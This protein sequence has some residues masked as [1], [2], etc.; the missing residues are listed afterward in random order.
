LIENK[1]KEFDG[2]RSVIGRLA[3][4]SM[5]TITL[6]DAD[7]QQLKTVYFF[8]NDQDLRDL[9]YVVS[10]YRTRTNKDAAWRKDNIFISYLNIGNIRVLNTQE[11]FS[12]MNEVHADTS[13]KP[14]SRGFVAGYGIA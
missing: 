14:R 1:I 8:K 4:S 9:G 3:D 6:D 11:E 7:L 2:D 10:S 5:E 12:F 13:I